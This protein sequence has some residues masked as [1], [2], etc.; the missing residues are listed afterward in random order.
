[1][2]SFLDVPVS[3]AYHLVHWIAQ[4][5]EP[6]TGPYSAALAIVLCTV[7]VRLAL[8]PLSVRAARGA[9]S[10][11]ALLPQLKELS[12]KHKN[13]P[14]RL[15]RE[16]AALQAESG[17]LFA[18][19][20]PLLA[21]LPFFWVLYSLF[22]T[23]VVAGQPNQ[24]LTGT[25]FGAPLGLHWPLLTSTPV[26]LGLAV[27]LAVVAYCSAH[28]QSRKAENQPDGLVG[29]LTRVLPYG[30]LVTAAFIPLAA[31]LYLLTTTT[32]AVAE[33]AILQR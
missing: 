25:L 9:K 22:S 23:A 20:L 29:Q 5:F 2:P 28:W 32:W 10:R 16:V 3:G 6:L 31:G 4:T 33:R 26:Y 13:N 11:T 15:N 1:M 27:L 8:L 14:E 21:Q 7:A 12:D 24:L 17:S 18:G 19:C 30:T